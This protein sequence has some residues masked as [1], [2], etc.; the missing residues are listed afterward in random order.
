MANQILLPEHQQAIR[1][2]VSELGLGDFRS[3]ILKS[4]YSA[5]N[6]I[7]AKQSD[8]RTLGTTRFGGQPDLPSTFETSELDSF[9]FLY[10]VNLSDLRDGFLLGLPAEGILSIFSNCDPYYGGKTL[11]FLSTDLVRHQMPNPT[12]D[13]IF[14]DLK[15]WKLKI[16]MSVGFAQYGVE[17]FDEIE[18]AGLSD[19]YETL[20]NTEFDSRTGP[21]FG[22]ILG[23]FSDLNE[24]M[25][26]DAANECGGKPN[27]WRSLWKLFSSFK[28][29]LV[30]SDFHLLH[31]M[32]RKRHLM[33]LDFTKM[34][35]T[36]D[37]G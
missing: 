14:S 30:I 26:E 24:D 36:Q 19:E 15:P 11:Y 1:E 2:R 7:G 17:L 22:E 10:Q 25:R 12:P 21:C 31:G 20:C 28:S 13:Y 9:Q 33:N 35:T 37:N 6:L 18:E 5:Y 27:E 23:R 3:A 16:A 34:Y 8:T 29:N 4:A 32:I